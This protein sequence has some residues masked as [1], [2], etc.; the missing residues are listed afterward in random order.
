LSYSNLSRMI[1]M[2]KQNRPL[3]PDHARQKIKTQ[4]H[5]KGT[6]WPEL[7]DPI[8]RALPEQ[9]ENELLNQ[10]DTIKRILKELHQEPDRNI[11][12]N[13][14]TTSSGNQQRDE[15]LIPAPTPRQLFVPFNDNFPHYLIGYPLFTFANQAATWNEQNANN[16]YAP[17][18]LF[19]HI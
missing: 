1:K 10:N 5:P 2:T 14:P 8:L 7:D 19:P 9:Q 13:H 3:N 4:R 17:L 18:A 11:N 12:R 16:P 6:H 15:I